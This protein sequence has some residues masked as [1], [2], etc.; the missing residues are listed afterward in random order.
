MARRDGSEPAQIGPAEIGAVAAI[1]RIASASG[2]VLLHVVVPGIAAGQVVGIQDAG[3]STEFQEVHRSGA[4]H[5]IHV[6]DHPGQGQGRRERPLRTRSQAAGAVGH[7]REVGEELAAVVVMAPQADILA[8]DRLIRAVRILVVVVVFELR[9]ERALAHGEVIGQTCVNVRPAVV[10][11]R[12]RT[13]THRGVGTRR[14]G[15]HRRSGCTRRPSGRIDMVNIGLAV[16]LIHIHYVVVGHAQIRTQALR[17]GGQILLEGH[18]SKEQ[19]VV[20]LVVRGST[21]L[22][23][24]VL[25]PR[26]GGVC[27]AGK[28]PV[29]IHHGERRGRDRVDHIP[30]IDVGT[31]TVVLHQ[32]TQQVDA[33]V[34]RRGQVD[35]QVEAHVAAN[36]FVLRAVALVHLGAVDEALVGDQVQHGEIAQTTLAAAELDVE[37]VG[38][39]RVLEHLVHPVHARID[40]GILA[41]LQS[42]KLVV[43]VLWRQA[44]GHTGLIDGQT[45]G[46]AVHEPGLVDQLVEHMVIGEAHHTGVGRTTLGRQQ[47][48]TVDAPVAVQGRRRR[49]LQDRHA[50]H[51]FRRHAP[52]RTLDTVD[53][54][55]RRGVAVQRL[56]TAH[57]ESRVH[58]RDIARS[59]QG[60]QTQALTDDTVANILGL[61]VPDLFRR[62]DGD[63][64]RGLLHRQLGPRLAG[65]DHPLLEPRV[66]CG[67]CHAEGRRQR[68]HDCIF[69]FHTF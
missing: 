6:G 42:G 26:P 63:R 50:L 53:Q 9:V 36:I 47:D 20:V 14:T 19:A 12:T 22:A 67:R 33:H 68:K 61:P 37:I 54:H 69:H 41:A 17:P 5:G 4:G 11:V 48:R 51:L 38:R 3:G 7:Q 23:H 66:L 45:V 29:G 52:D 30:R 64:R 59:L 25:G 21:G 35:V 24:R 49:I 43:V 57:V 65:L 10:G 31:R 60:D 39:S 15:F 32:H 56:E 55:Q 18:V 16:V 13:R 2:R 40:I 1:E 27:A 62:D 46:I 58:V 44:I 34:R 28:I 8:V